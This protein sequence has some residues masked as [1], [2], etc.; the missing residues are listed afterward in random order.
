MINNRSET[1]AHTVSHILNPAYL[2][3]LLLIIIGIACPVVMVGISGK[4]A[5]GGCLFFL[6]FL[7][8]CTA[9]ESV[10]LRRFSLNTRRM[11][12]F[13]TSLISYIAC[14]VTA[15]VSKAPLLF[16]TIGASYLGTV[17]L[18]ILTNIFFRASGH[19]SAVSGPVIALNLIF[20]GWGLLSLPLLA[21]VAWARLTA[22][23]HTLLQVLS[24]MAIGAFSTVMAFILI[25]PV[26]F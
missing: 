1:L 19:G 24:G 6:V 15:L 23:E 4:M 13:I 18:L 16:I 8:A 10:L 9:Q 20:P 7:P 12:S 11:I 14:F 21:V 25:R 5:W 26:L 17:L 2:A 3:L 22:K